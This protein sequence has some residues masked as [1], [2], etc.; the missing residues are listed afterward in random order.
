MM[1]EAL[2]A[3]EQV[4]RY[5]PHHAEAQFELARLVRNQKAHELKK[6]AEL[7]LAMRQYARAERAIDEALRLCPD[8][9][10]GGSIKERV[11]G[12][13]EEISKL[14]HEARTL[15]ESGRSEAAMEILE[16]LHEIYPGYREAGRL[17]RQL[18]N[19]K[20]GRDG[21]LLTV[22][23]QRGIDKYVLLMKQRV[24]IGRHES[25]DIIL[26][27]IST[28]RHHAL[29][30]STGGA[31]VIEDLGSK[32]GTF[33]AGRQVVDT[34][35]KSGDVIDFGGDS[36]LIFTLDP[37]RRDRAGQTTSSGGARL[38]L[39]VGGKRNIHYLLLFETIGLGSR[40]ECEISIQDEGVQELHAR[41]GYRDG[42]FVV[43]PATPQ[44]RILLGGKEIESATPI[45]FGDILS[46]G[47][48]EV[49]FLDYHY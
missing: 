42:V 12:I 30:H 4:L 14:Y 43:E 22:R 13:V 44:S 32:N 36:K 18:E 24:S 19:P 6:E 20:A 7:S 47:K 31:F 11:A 39:S 5:D 27:D 10:D 26:E 35:L 25:N 48:A 23:C 34:A 38:T 33:I 29:I 28:S 8:L 37:A 15:A 46:L 17:L 49:Y 41:L 16:K 3:T 21:V 2:E 9:P 45:S 40:P 1:R